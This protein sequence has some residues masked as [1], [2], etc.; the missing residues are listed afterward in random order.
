MSFIVRQ[1]DTYRWDITDRRKKSAELIIKL[2]YNVA[3]RA[4]S[5]EAK[6]RYSKVSPWLKWKP[7]NTAQIALAKEA[8]GAAELARCIAASLGAESQTTTTVVDSAFG[9]FVYHSTP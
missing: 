8:I 6:R 7:A 3:A 2:R 9:Q 1:R 4:F 5:G